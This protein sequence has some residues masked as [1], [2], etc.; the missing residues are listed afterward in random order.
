MWD[1]EIMVFSQFVSAVCSEDH[2]L[3]RFDVIKSSLTFLVRPGV[4]I[5]CILR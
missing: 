4:E 5:T 2:D 1:Q 3:V